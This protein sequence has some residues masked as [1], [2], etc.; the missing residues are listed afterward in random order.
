[1]PAIPKPVRKQRAADLREAGARQASRFFAA[2]IGQTVSLLTEASQSGHSEHFAP[3]RLAQPSEPGR[4]LRAK[5]TGATQEH[6][7]AEAA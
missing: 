5:V 4:L 3:V 2:Q 7:L 6:L 1:M